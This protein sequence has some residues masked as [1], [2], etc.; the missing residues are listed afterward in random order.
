MLQLVL[1]TLLAFAAGCSTSLTQAKHRYPQPTSRLHQSIPFESI[2][3]SQKEVVVVEAPDFLIQDLQLE[4][5][6][7][8]TVFNA[9]KLVKPTTALANVKRAY[10]KI[11]VEVFKLLH[12]R[13]YAVFVTS[14]LDRQAYV[15]EV[16]NQDGEMT[17]GY[18]VID[19]ERL[20]L[21]AQDWANGQIKLVAPEIKD[22]LSAEFATKKEDHPSLV[23]RFILAEAIGQLIALLNPDAL[24][25]F[26]VFSWRRGAGGVDESIQEPA[27]GFRSRPFIFNSNEMVK[28]FD[29][30]NSSNLPTLYA[31]RSPIADFSESLAVYLHTQVYHQPLAWNYRDQTVHHYQSCMNSN[32]CPEKIAFFSNHFLVQARK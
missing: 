20:N 19:Y 31:T 23:F 32:R 11:P 18:I 12:G 25:R 6:K 14:G 2:A 13:V 3:G 24:Q 22:S 9:R 4:A 15:N 30:M 27:L 5:Q 26:Y 29:R 16:Y 10:K 17:G 7:S 21:K 28:V 1:M 8:G